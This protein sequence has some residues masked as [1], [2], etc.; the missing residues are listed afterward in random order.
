M[1][2]WYKKFAMTPEKQE[3]DK[4]RHQKEK[5]QRELPSKNNKHPYILFGRRV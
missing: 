1:S 4:K 3:R 2:A 5:G